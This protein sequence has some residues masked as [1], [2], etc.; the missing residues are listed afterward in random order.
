[1]RALVAAALP[2]AGEIRICNDAVAVGNAI[3]AD[4]GEGQAGDVLVLL[5]S[6]GIGSVTI[7][8]G[9]VVE[10]HNGFAGEIG[11]MVL[12]PKLALGAPTF[13][14]LAGERVFAPFLPAGRPLIETVPELAARAPEAGLAAAL[15]CWAEH[16]AAGL[17][18]AIWLLDPARI[19]V[20][21][22][23]ALLYPR[24]ADRVSALLAG[25]MQGVTVPPVTISR[26]GGDGAAVGAAAMIRERVFAL[27]T[28]GD[29]GPKDFEGIAG[30]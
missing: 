13:Q 29:K 19:V 5:L 4:A 21:G 20:S 22:T 9:Q 30:T 10:G 26:Y 15:D 1:L 14:E 12:A 24:V 6:E 17:L 16:L 2:E 25:A 3:C 7:R 27:P 8:Q 11:Q 18:N 28:V 23:L